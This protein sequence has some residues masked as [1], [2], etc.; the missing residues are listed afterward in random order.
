MIFNFQISERIKMKKSEKMSAQECEEI[1]LKE[2]AQ[3][4]TNAVNFMQIQIVGKDFPND[5]EKIL[6]IF[7]I[8]HATKINNLRNLIIDELALYKTV[9][10][11]QLRDLDKQKN[12]N[13]LIRYYPR[14]VFR[15]MLG[16]YIEQRFET[17]AEAKKFLKTLIFKNRTIRFQSSHNKNE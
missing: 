8:L 3:N 6:E 13:F 14:I 16:E 4:A 11:S 1:S 10:Q 7:L 17:R 9:F 12:K 2:L 15:K 5:L